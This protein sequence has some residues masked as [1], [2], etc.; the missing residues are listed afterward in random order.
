MIQ[1]SR[2]FVQAAATN[3]ESL[4]IG[5]GPDV[6]AFA[7]GRAKALVPAVGTPVHLV[8]PQSAESATDAR[9]SA[10]RQ[11]L[12]MLSAAAYAGDL[13]RNSEGLGL[14][15]LNLQLTTSLTTFAGKTY[16][17]F[18]GNAGGKTFTETSIEPSQFVTS[19]SQQANIALVPE[20]QYLNE[21]IA[22]VFFVNGGSAAESLVISFQVDDFAAPQQNFA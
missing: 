17:R 8:I 18:T 19:E 5:F 21:N 6:M 4:T 3:A 15:L 12:S 9:A 7:A 16:Y 1:Y 2:N 14:R 11:I 20:N 10:D 22:Y 13:Q